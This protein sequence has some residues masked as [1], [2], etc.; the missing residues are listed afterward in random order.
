LWTALTEIDVKGDAMSDSMRKMFG[1]LFLA[2]IGIGWLAISLLLLSAMN[3]WA[4]SQSSNKSTKTHGD[5]KRGRAVFNGKGVCYYC[6]VVDGYLDQRPQLEA[7]TAAFIA[8]LNPQPPDL[9]DQKVL[10]LKSDKQRR[11]AIRVGHPGTGMF[12]DKTMT[13]QELADT[14]VYLSTLRREGSIKGPSH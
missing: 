10:H 3:T 14:I 5:A 2:G 1:A 8:G 4:G 7:D 6:H 9:R 13:D 11:R 12:P